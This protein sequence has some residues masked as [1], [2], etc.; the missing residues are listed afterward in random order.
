MGDFAQTLNFLGLSNTIEEVLDTCSVWNGTEETA[1]DERP[2]SILQI[3]SFT[4]QVQLE[5]ELSSLSAIPPVAILTTIQERKKIREILEGHGVRMVET[6][7]QILFKIASKKFGSKSARTRE[8]LYIQPTIRDKK[9]KQDCEAIKALVT[10]LRSEKLDDRLAII[11]GN[12]GFGKT[13]FCKKLVSRLQSLPNLTRLPIYID[14][15]HWRHLVNEKRFSV[16]SA[17]SEAVANAYPNSAIGDEAI[18]HLIS[19][20]AILPIFDG[21]D[22]LC[23]DAYTEASVGDIIDQMENIFEE[24]SAGKAIFTSRSTFWAD[25]RSSERMKLHEYEVLPFDSVQRDQ[26][27]DGWFELHAG[28]RT[29]A[30]Q[31]LSIVDSSSTSRKNSKNGK[32]IRFS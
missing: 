25:A 26:F 14:S 20:G 15:N 30:E 7:D 28:N 18:E 9:S 16:R 29:F 22:E 13:T 5:R 23:T 11:T 12:A 4:S 1:F 31:T 8:E 17:C 6:E 10:W 21:L 32:S 19:R 24:D 3:R 27:L 2:V